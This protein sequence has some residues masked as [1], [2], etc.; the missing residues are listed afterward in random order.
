MYKDLNLY[1]QF[2]QYGLFG[3]FRILLM[4]LRTK[5]FYQKARLI[6]FPFY[7]RGRQNIS[8]GNEFTTGVGVRIE[9]YSSSNK[10]I[11]NIGKNVQLNDYVHIAGINKVSIGDN[12]L[13]ASRVFI[14]DHNHGCYSTP[15]LHSKPE[16]IPKNRPLVAKPI[17]IESNVWIGEG[18][19]ILPGVKI[20]FG[21]IVAAGSVVTKD[22]PRSSIAAGNPAKIIKKY[23]TKA[24][25]WQSI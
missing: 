24:Q 20:G 5:L 22:I 12:V 9:A 8:W 16:E 25:K 10:V 2:K 21:S 15:G 13:I 6:R 1:A 18:V 7:L 14:S 4:W 3:F 19:F 11:V 17:L 23:N